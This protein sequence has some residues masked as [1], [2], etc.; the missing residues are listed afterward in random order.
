VNFQ[1]PTLS[2]WTGSTNFTTGIVFTLAQ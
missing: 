1:D 2:G